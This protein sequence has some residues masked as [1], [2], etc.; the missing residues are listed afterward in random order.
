MKYISRLKVNEGIQMLQQWL[1]EQANKD[2]VE[3]VVHCA[4][5]RYYAPY[6]RTRPYDC[7]YMDGVMSS[8]FCSRGKRI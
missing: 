3:E 8:D 6:D 1:K 4:N 5:C 2:E 7:K